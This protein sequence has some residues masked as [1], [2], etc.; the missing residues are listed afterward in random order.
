M[1][2][3]NCVCRII[4]DY[5]RMIRIILLTTIPCTISCPSFLPQFSNQCE[6]Y[7]R[8]ELW[9]HGLGAILWMQVI[10]C[11]GY[12]IMQ[13]WKMGRKKLKFTRIEKNGQWKDVAEQDCYLVPRLL[14][15]VQG[16][17]GVR[18]EIVANC[19]IFWMNITLVSLAKPSTHK[20][21]KNRRKWWNF[22]QESE[23]LPRNT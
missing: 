1:S 16:G 3:W 20:H 8:Q 2:A 6:K 9:K 11:Y 23:A 10:A 18:K 15:F 7:S 13:I 19:L 21:R 22:V 12:D 5:D 4:E 14:I 17:V